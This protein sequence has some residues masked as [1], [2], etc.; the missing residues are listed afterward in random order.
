MRSLVVIVV[1]MSGC[2]WVLSLYS[3]KPDGPP[4]IDAAPDSSDSSMFPDCHGK[5]DFTPIDEA[6]EFPGLVTVYVP[7]LRDDLHEVFEVEGPPYDIVRWYKPTSTGWFSDGAQSFNVEGQT[8]DDPALTG[9]GLLLAFSSDRTG[10]NLGYLVTRPSVDAPWGAVTA[11]PGLAT[12]HMKQVDL[13]YDGLTLYF[14]D[15]IDHM[16]Q[17]HRSDRNSMFDSDMQVAIAR[18]PTVSSDGLELFTEL[19]GTPG[20]IFYETRATPTGLFNLVG[21]VPTL[22]GAMDIDLTSDGSIMA[23]YGNHFYRRNCQ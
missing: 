20:K 23:A 18:Y 3:F 21:E 15:D 10:P 16:H 7:Q 11:I 22:A 9:D 17:A 5:I 13:S 1:A 12:S 2:D 19:P 4:P 6:V 14:V 8:N